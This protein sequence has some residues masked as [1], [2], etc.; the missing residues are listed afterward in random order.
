MQLVEEERAGVT[1]GAKHTCCL[2]KGRDGHREERERCARINGCIGHDKGSHHRLQVGP[3]GLSKDDLE[4]MSGHA[5]KPW[6][7]PCKIRRNMR[8]LLCED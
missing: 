2:F 6:Y 5:N 7:L 4:E 1:Y 3:F 8:S